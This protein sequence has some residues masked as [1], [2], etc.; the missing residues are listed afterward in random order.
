MVTRGD[1]TLSASDDGRYCPRVRCT[2]CRHPARQRIDQALV[3]GVSLRTIAQHEGL[4]KSVLGRHR[5]HR[6]GLLVSQKKWDTTPAH[7]R[8]TVMS[9][10]TPGGILYAI[11]APGTP[12]VKIGRT[13]TPVEKRLGSLQSGYPAPLQVFAAVAIPE[14]LSTIEAY[15]HAFLHKER[16]RGEWFEVEIADNAQLEAVIASAMQ[17]A[18]E[19][20][21]ETATYQ[22]STPRRV[23]LE[24]LSL[25]TLR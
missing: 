9:K 6:P 19:Q 7:K 22:E 20:E 4:S 21:A 13:R 12:Y 25:D 1:E 2:I 23:Q 15:V 3:S 17:Y 24:L 8:P 14:N 5:E 16:R 18:A 10:P 11:G